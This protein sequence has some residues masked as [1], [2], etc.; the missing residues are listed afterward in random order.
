MMKV[1]YPAVISVHDDKRL[2]RVSCA[3]QEVPSRPN[4]AI[5]LSDFKLPPSISRTHAKGEDREQSLASDIPS[6]GVGP[7]KSCTTMDYMES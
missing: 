2:V 1:M 3:L 5:S 4:S 6:A 7:P